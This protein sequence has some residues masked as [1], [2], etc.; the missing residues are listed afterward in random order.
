MNLGSMSGTKV[1]RFIVK[2]YMWDKMGRIYHLEFI[3]GPKQAGF[4]VYRPHVSRK[5]LCIYRLAA[6]YWLKVGGFTV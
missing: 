2:C 3:S 4:T 6:I 1:V 5:W